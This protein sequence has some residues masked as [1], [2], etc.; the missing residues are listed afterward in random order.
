MVV[1]QI[2]AVFDNFKTYEA[3]NYSI[4]SI[5]TNASYN[6]VYLDPPY[7]SN[8]GIGVNYRSFY[9]FLEGI[10]NYHEWEKSNN[11]SNERQP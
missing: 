10:C 1:E 7:V 8:E 4:L 5:P 11:P 3:I 9:H 2:R 6:L